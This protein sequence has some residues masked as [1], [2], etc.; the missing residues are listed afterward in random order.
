MQQK[1]MGRSF[2]LVAAAA[3]SACSS[4]PQSLVTAPTHVRPQYSA[5]VLEENPGAIYQPSRAT[6]LFEEPIAGRVGDEL[7]INISENLTSSNTANTSTSTTTTVSETGPGAMSSMGGLL[8]EIFNY[9]GKGGGGKSLNGQAKVSNASTLSGNLMVTVTEVLPNNYLAVA[10]EKAV[11][12]SGSTTVLRFSG[13]VNRR[14]IKAGNVVS[15][16]NVADA[17]IEQ[18]VDGVAS[19]VVSRTQLQRFL[20]DLI[21]FW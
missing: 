21:N 17:R 6:L 4:T 5:T 12:A 15:S 7:Q 20:T 3:L 11:A 9:S 13:V 16:D 10:G 2:P 1:W 8:K 14:D 19:Q 18:V